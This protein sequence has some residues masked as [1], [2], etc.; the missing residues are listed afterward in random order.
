LKDKDLE[1]KTGEKKVSCE[2]TFPNIKRYQTA[3]PYLLPHPLSQNLPLIKSQTTEI[4][5]W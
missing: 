5:F 3:W 4:S 2:E 1:E